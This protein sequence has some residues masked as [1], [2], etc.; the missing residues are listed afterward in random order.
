M[1]PAPAIFCSAVR[2]GPASHQYRDR[3]ADF[4]DVKFASY[5][6]DPEFLAIFRRHKALE[7]NRSASC[8]RLAGAK[9]YPSHT[10][11][12]PSVSN[13]WA[14]RFSQPCSFPQTVKEGAANPA[15]R[16]RGGRFVW[17]NFRNW[18]HPSFNSACNISFMYAPQSKRKFFDVKRQEH[19]IIPCCMPERMR[20]RSHERARRGNHHR[21]TEATKLRK[22]RKIWAF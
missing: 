22:G 2:C 21:D 17:Q 16:N 9:L 12:S 3:A 6:Q 14:N 8:R 10:L 7:I 11:A 19:T 5:G 4:V 13:S 18:R 1:V 15:H 20:F